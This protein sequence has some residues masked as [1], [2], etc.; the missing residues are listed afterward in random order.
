MEVLALLF[1]VQLS[2]QD[3]LLLAGGW[4]GTWRPLASINTAAKNNRESLRL[5]PSVCQSQE[6]RI[7]SK[8]QNGRFH[9]LEKKEN[10]A[11][12]IIMS[13]QMQKSV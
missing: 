11:V 10:K 12:K 5:L 4:V 3:E 1:E 7:I 6:R 2:R 8:F 9:Q 13:Y